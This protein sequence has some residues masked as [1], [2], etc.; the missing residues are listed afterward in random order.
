MLASFVDDPVT[1][2]IA[3]AVVIFV[4]AAM[5]RR[6]KAGR[7]MGCLIPVAVVFVVLSLVFL[8]WLVDDVF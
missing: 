5:P 8:D 4:L 6:W 1:L 7:A 2:P 3:I